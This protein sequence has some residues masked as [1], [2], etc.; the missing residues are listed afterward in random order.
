MNSSVSPYRAIPNNVDRATVNTGRVE[1]AFVLDNLA[2][3]E[4][5]AQSIPPGVEVVIVD[6]RGDGL[7]QIS[8]YLAL[9]EAASVDA[10]HLFSHGQDSQINLG[11]TVLNGDKLLE[12][13]T[14]SRLATL[15][16]AMSSDGDL[17]LYG[18]NVAQGA[19]GQS[20]ISRLSELTGADVAA[21]EDATGAAR[22]GGNWVLESASGSISATSLAAE[23]YPDLWATSPMSF[24]LT[25][26]AIRQSG[27]RLLT[28]R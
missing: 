8:D 20:F 11:E 17:L 24:P 26:L 16:Q 27:Y 2:D 5:L 25:S 22:W 12:T 10:V 28:I 9:K 7:T 23:D 21:S 13:E 19:V 6:S 14:L 3:W 15:R 1:I 18:C 4:T